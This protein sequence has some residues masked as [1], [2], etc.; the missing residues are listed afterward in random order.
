M[1][2]RTIIIFGY[3]S[4]ASSLSMVMNRRGLGTW[5]SA[6]SRTRRDEG[7]QFFGLP[8]AMELRLLNLAKV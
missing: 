4:P 8:K 2:G 1:L 3:F 7:S 5:S 6:S